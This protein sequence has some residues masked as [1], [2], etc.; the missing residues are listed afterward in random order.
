MMPGGG[1][2]VTGLAAGLR[3]GAKGPLHA[4]MDTETIYLVGS[5]KDFQSLESTE[6]RRPRVVQKEW[7]GV[8]SFLAVF[9]LG[10][11]LVDFLEHLSAFLGSLFI[12]R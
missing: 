9:T 2:R 4:T 7:G 6:G 5:A 11:L 12:T 10:L 8:S 1:H 3:P